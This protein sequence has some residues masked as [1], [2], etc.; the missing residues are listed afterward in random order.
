[1]P[2]KHNSQSDINAAA[3]YTGLRIVLLSGSLRLSGSST[4]ILALQRALRGVGCPVVHI[5][6]GEPSQVAIPNDLEVHYTGKARRHWLLRMCRIVQLHKLLPKWFEA[7]TDRVISGR[8]NA[9]LQQLCWQDHLD[10]VIKD[11]TCDT[12]TCLKVWPLVAVIHQNLSP[13][14]HEPGMRL[15]AEPGFMCCGIKGRG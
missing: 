9:V 10:L 3:P 14:W 15:K 13:D 6:M 11:F 1:M 5:A 7:K 8:V 2:D 12:P 4:W